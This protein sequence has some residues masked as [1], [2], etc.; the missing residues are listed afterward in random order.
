MLE[1]KRILMVYFTST[2]AQAKEF[3]PPVHQGEAQ[4]GA[5]ETNPRA[6]CLPSPPTWWIGCTIN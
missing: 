4:A 5:P 3:A 2:Q 6:R 1:A